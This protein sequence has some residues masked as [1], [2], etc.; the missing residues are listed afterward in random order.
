MT[1]NR[2]F[3]IVLTMALCFTTTLYQAQAQQHVSG[4]NGAP[5]PASATSVINLSMLLARQRKGKPRGFSLMAES[6]NTVSSG[7]GLNII[8]AAAGNLPVTGS[9]TLGRLTKW[10]GFTSSNSVIGDTTIYEDKYGLVGIGT[11]SP[12]SKLTVNGMIQ[13]L[14][15]GLKFPDGTVQT[16][17]A[18]GALLSIAHDTTLAGDGT[19][20]SPLA[21]RVPLFLTASS[22]DV[23]TARQNG[24]CTGCSAITGFAEDASIGVTGAVTAFVPV[25]RTG[26]QGISD[27]GI[28]VLG[29]S[30]T[31]IGVM[32]EGSL[33]GVKGGGTGTG[34]SGLGGSRTN[35][36]GGIGVSAHGGDGGGAGNRG[37]VGIY[38][39]GGLGT[40]GAI[41]GLAGFFF[42][43][44]QVSGT[45]SKG[46]GA[47]KIDHPLD[48]ENKYLSH[49]F[50]ESPDMMNIYNGNISTDENGDAVVELPEY[51]GALNKD[52]RYQLTVIGTF[53]QAIVSQK[54]KDNRFVIKTSAPNVEVSWQVTGIRRDAFA[55]HNRI[56]VEEDKSEIE[57][58]YY[59][60][61][62][63]FD[64]PEEKSINSARHPEG[65]QLHKQ[66]TIQAEPR[67]RRE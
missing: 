5:A 9:G 1:M 48:P 56:Q 12:A 55:N 36:F 40:G 33:I 37:G 44:V 6:R 2:L 23:F 42:G 63:A 35:G 67:M 26:V 32:G 30:K 13:S 52:F 21:I 16:S 15:G 53:A 39:V 61:P 60:H 17:S 18:T 62:Q 29:Q 59:L 3:S 65:M 38:A 50:V 46:G 24:G 8:P 27:T 34:V 20:S 54:I 7:A 28:G 64:Q 4:S 57:R 14:S 49:S 31:D 66:R 41:D 58:G 47:F 19:S 11:D 22:T 10:I 25:P 43:N 45:L 51:F